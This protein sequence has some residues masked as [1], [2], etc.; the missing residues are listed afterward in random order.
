MVHS[1]VNDTITVQELSNVHC[2]FYWASI[3]RA[4]S[5]FYLTIGKFVSDWEITERKGEREGERE[6]GREEG[7]EGGRE[8]VRERGRE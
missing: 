1:H 3:C 7:R 5:A 4:N 8:G 2:K 6:G